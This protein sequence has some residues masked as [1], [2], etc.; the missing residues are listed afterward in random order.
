MNAMFVLTKNESRS[1]FVIVP[2]RLIDQDLYRRHLRPGPETPRKRRA[3][4]K[5]HRA[6]DYTCSKTT[7]D[8]QAFWTYN[9][10]GKNRVK[11]KTLP[12]TQH[13]DPH[14]LSFSNML[15]GVIK[16]VSGCVN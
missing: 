13:V 11:M 7:G 4:E 15:I 8:L 12:F 9:Y 5:R 6:L 10:E 3:L 16:K 2:C 1:I 14:N